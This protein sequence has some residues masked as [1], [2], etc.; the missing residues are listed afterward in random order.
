MALELGACSAPA[1]D[2]SFSLTA[3][4]ILGGNP[5]GGAILRSGG[6]SGWVALQCWAGATTAVAALAILVVR[7]PKSL[8]LLGKA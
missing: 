5:I 3:I 7:F 6:G 1:I 8:K 2:M 4:G